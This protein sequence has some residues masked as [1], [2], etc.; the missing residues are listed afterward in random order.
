MGK[1]D[2]GTRSLP[3]VPPDRLTVVITMILAGANR[4]EIQGHAKREAWDLT[5]KKLDDLID[6]AH[7]EIGIMCSEDREKVFN[8]AVARLTG[9]YAR[10]QKIQDYKTALNIQKEINRL[11][12]I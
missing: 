10:A 11:Y 9:L 4:R 12:G 6:R 1:A 5:P 7:H 3:A 2:V 8:L